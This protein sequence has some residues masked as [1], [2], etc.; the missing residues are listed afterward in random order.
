MTTRW[1]GTPRSR[2]D[3]KNRERSQQDKAGAVRNLERDL[4]GMALGGNGATPDKKVDQGITDTDKSPVDKPRVRRT[5]KQAQGELAKVAGARFRTVPGD[6]SCF[7]HVT[8][9]AVGTNVSVQTLR[10]R[11]GCSD[12]TTQWAEENHVRVLGQSMGLRFYFWR[13]ELEQDVIAEPTISWHVA[14]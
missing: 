14:G 1:G 9:R 7:F 8:R 12:T 11:A 10:H 4:C 13:I 3:R 5:L 6:G 2:S